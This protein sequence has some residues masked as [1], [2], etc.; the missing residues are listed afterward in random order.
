MRSSVWIG[1]GALVEAC[2]F[3][4]GVVVLV[5]LQWP[6]LG[7]TRVL[8]HDHL[9]WGV[10]VYSFFAESVA[11]GRLPLWNPFS[12]GGEPFY[13]PLF[14]L[15]LLDPSA[16]LVALAGGWLGADPITLYGWDRLVRGVVIGAGSY[17][18]LRLWAR[19]LLTRLS[20][21]PIVLFSSMQWSPLRQMAIAEQYLLGPLA[22][23]FVLRIVYL[24]DNR[25]RNW[26]AAAFLLGLNFQSYFFS[27]TVIVITIFGVGLLMFRRSLIRRLWRR[28]GLAGRLAAAATIVLVMALP[29]VVLLSENRQFIFPPRVVD[30]AY[31]DRGPNQGPPQHEP[32]GEIRSRRPLLF[33]YRLQ[34]HVGTYSAPDD[35]VQM[36]A[37]FASEFAR[38][39]G[40]SWGK[41]SEAFIYVGMLPLAV[42][43]LGLVAGR[44]SLKRVWLLILVSVGLLMLGP[45]AFVHALLYWGF[46]P[47]W[48]VRNM[49]TLV[50]FFVLAL[51]YFYVLGCNRILGR[52]ATPLLPTGA[53]PGTLARVL[54]RPRLATFAATLGLAV[55][56]LALVVTLSRVRYPLTFYTLPA[57]A[58]VAAVGWW[59][60]ADVGPRGLYWSVLTGWA[61]AV[62][63]LAARGHDR[64][65]VFFLLLFLALPLL[66]WICWTARAR[67]WARLGIG[68]ALI[69]AVAVGVYRLAPFVREPGTDPGLTPGLLLALAGAVV[70]AVVLVLVARDVLRDG[71]RVLSRGS[72]AAALALISALDLVAYSGYLRPLVEGPRP[73]RG[74]LAA[75]A[76]AG[77]LPPARTVTVLAPSSSRLEQPIRY[78]EVLEK[79]PTAF[80]P[81]FR[82]P[83]SPPPGSDPATEIEGL[84]RGARASTFLMTRGYYD[85]VRAGASGAVLAE[86]FEIDRPLV[87]L[88]PHWVWLDRDTA[89]RFLAD[90]AKSQ[91]FMQSSVL[92][93]RRP[94]TLDEGSAEP[95]R[96]A[97]AGPGRVDIGRWDYNT[98]ALDVDA[99]AA[100]VLYW[101]DG[102][103]PSWRAWVDGKEVAVHRANLA[104]KAVFVPPGRHAV[105]FE[106]RPTAIVVT[107]LLFVAMGFAGAILG[108]WALASAPRLPRFGG[109]A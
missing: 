71:S 99:P 81:L 29:S 85:L 62:V 76:A 63:V 30:Y 22:L 25:W 48:F 105:R 31:E 20:L 74:P 108:V 106:Y 54:G 95:G 13:L 73:E 93:E 78:R 96:G 90:P 1:R 49:H 56:V 45:Q 42:A 67:K 66:T 15:R 38:P 72:L 58:C 91:A 17:L 40:H 89:R 37:P 52:R 68:V 14:Q 9:Y 44:N 18:V 103:D 16:L 94:A 47:L 34:F 4:V 51:L 80:S 97:G 23:L 79:V 75:A 87:Q 6:A 82:A 10:P 28:P 27:G 55:A 101:A 8:G 107:G 109:R 12:H 39:A 84:L 21:I 104:F 3:L 7:G 88:R 98:L 32:T 19:H 26:L 70:G 5:L 36:F 60:R 46:P 35:F 2:A 92:L 86:I 50:L 83:D 100:A 53:A 69:G 59:L 11:L 61:G 57:L 33:P 24:E 65:S 64:T 41:P 77:T 43:L 102:F